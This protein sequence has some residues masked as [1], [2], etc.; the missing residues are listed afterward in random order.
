MKNSQI[1]NS[2]LLISAI[3]LIMGCQPNSENNAP[4]QPEEITET[5][6]LRVTSAP[7]AAQV[8]VNNELKGSTPLE[9]YNFPVGAYNVLVK[10]AGYA[11]F[12]KSATVKAGITEEVNAKLSPIEIAAP[13]QPA[14]EKNTPTAPTQKMN[15]ANINGSFIIY[16]DFKRGLFTETSSGD[17]DVFSSN[18]GTYIYFT[19]ISPVLMGVVNK[20]IGNIKREDC[21]YF[22]E[23][24]ANLY[25]GQTLCVKTT[26]GKIAAVGGKWSEKA[27]KLEW[28]LFS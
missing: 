22:T 19:A 13:P 26:N 18:Y 15:T 2:I 10:K 6:I 8:Y 3:I 11:D 23:T 16:Y 12:E 7:S 9:L 27:D 17:P 14:G 1:M 20:P 28:I 4:S 24:I 21:Q 25:S 5:G